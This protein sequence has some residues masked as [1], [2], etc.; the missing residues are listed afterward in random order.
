M[1]LHPLA[2]YPGLYVLAPSMVETP[3]GSGL[4][5]TLDLPETPPGSGLY[6]LGVDRGFAPLLTVY[7]EERPPGMPSERVPGYYGPIWKATVGAPYVEVLFEEFDPATVTVTVHRSSGGRDQE[8][9]G[10]IRAP[11]AGSLTRLDHEVGTGVES[12][13]WAEMFDGAGL[14][15]GFTAPAV[16]TV[17]DPDTWVHNPLNPQ[18]S[19]RVRLLRGAAKELHRPSSGT[20]F[21]PEGRTVG[22]LISGARQG[23]T[24]VDLTFY[25]ATFA[26]A[27]RL[28]GMLGG[29]STRRVPVLCIRTPPPM[30]IPR[31]LFA[32]VLDAGEIDIAVSTGREHLAWKI[33]GDEVAPPAPALFVP[34]LTRAD[35]NAFYATRAELNSDNLT[36]LAV[37]RRYDLAGTV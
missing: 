15:L 17:I 7:S 2:G 31:P 23:L 13:Y 36:R 8:V 24:G 6:A 9:R 25:T 16:V 33:T 34:L 35:L 3:P 21:Y 10:A 26:D 22:V 11:V 14:P 29:Y 30:R 12:T 1:A 18:E 20:V 37:N 32:A 19:I 4:Y 5:T 28:Q 27:D